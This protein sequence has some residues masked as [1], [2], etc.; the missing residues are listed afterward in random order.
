[1][2]LKRRIQKCLTA[3][4]SFSMIQGTIIMVVRNAIKKARTNDISN[5]MTSQHSLEYLKRIKNF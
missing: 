3:C 1:M 2:K 4:F 5:N